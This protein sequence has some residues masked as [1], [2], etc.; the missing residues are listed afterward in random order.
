M[1][2]KKLNFTLIELLVVIAIIAILAALLLPAL[3]K[4]RERARSV[5][6]ISNQ[7]QLGNSFTFYIDSYNGWLPEIYDASTVYWTYKLMAG[8]FANRSNFICPSMAVHEI[9]WNAVV[10][11]GWARANPSSLA[12]TYPDFGMLPW[13][14]W[15]RAGV[16]IGKISKAKSPSKSGL[17]ADNSNRTN[18]RGYYYVS[19]VYSAG[20]TIPVIAARHAGAVNC[21][22][23]DGHTETIQT[24]V[25]LPIPYSADS[26]PYLHPTLNL[27]P[28]WP[29]YPRGNFWIP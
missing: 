28:L 2:N 8:D 14:K 21:L 9:D 16:A 7:K 6:C 15:P 10:S 12:F 25:K 5:N 22:M 20:V 3:N 23:L 24:N 18:V 13:Y 17:T 29:L 1:R 19:D 27:N 26:N 11:A 4:A